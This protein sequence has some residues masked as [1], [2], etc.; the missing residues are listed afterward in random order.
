MKEIHINPYI[1]NKWIDIGFIGD[2]NETTLVFDVEGSDYYL[3]VQNNINEYLQFPIP[4]NKFVI[5][6]TFT[7]KS[8]MQ[9]QLVKIIDGELIAHGNI[10]NLNL[11]QSIKENDK[12]IETVPPN[13]KTA[14]DD[15]V[16]VTQEIKTAYENG[17]L[18]GEK[19]DKGDQ[20]IPGKDGLNG[21]DGAQGEKGEPGENG[22][23]PVK[24]VDYFTEVEKQEF[25]EII[26]S[27]LTSLLDK[28]IDKNQG[29]ENN[30][31]ILGIDENGDVVPVVNNGVNKEKWKLIA[32]I[33][34]S[35]PLTSI[36]ISEDIDGN[37][38]NLSKVFILAEI[39]PTENSADLYGSVSLNSTTAWGGVYAF[40]AQKTGSTKT[41][42][43][44]L[45]ENIGEYVIPT[46]ARATTGIN[47]KLYENYLD[48]S[49]GS[50]SVTSIDPFEA[51][52]TTTLPVTNIN[53]GSYTNFFYPGSIIKIW[54]VEI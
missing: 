18:K 3:K 16:D 36:N 23:T 15:M 37:P 42:N 7:Q 52:G 19:G 43:M 22:Y 6:S 26:K 2:H 40:K 9:I 39:Q 20:G 11:K 17:E 8:P 46:I 10:I 53:I 14:Y 12:T 32:N 45:A 34:V 27:D 38:L 33:K 35:E 24:G 21:K 47:Y 5:T 50:I 48:N 49:S 54:G 29:I 31:K 51:K 1:D 30:G 28:K 44:Y 4:N 13:F 41:Y 25:E